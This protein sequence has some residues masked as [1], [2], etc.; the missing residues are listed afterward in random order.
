[1]NMSISRRKFLRGLG[2]A[3][4]VTPLVPILKVAP[5]DHHGS[6]HNNDV[7]AAHDDL[8][9]IYPWGRKYDMII[10]DDPYDMSVRAKA[11]RNL[12]DWYNSRIDTEVFRSLYHG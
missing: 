4:V 11:R 3:A 2:A 12:K 6:P 5:L 1:V 7:V 9:H 10:V 8:D